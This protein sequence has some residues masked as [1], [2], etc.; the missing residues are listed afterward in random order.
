ML[1]GGKGHEAEW[2]GRESCRRADQ[3]GPVGSSTPEPALGGVAVTVVEDLI[4]RKWIADIVSAE[5]ISTQAEIAFTDA[6][7]IEGLLGGVE[8]RADGRVDPT[9]DDESRPILLAVSDNGPQMTSGSTQDGH[10]RHRPA[11][12]PAQH[13]HRP[14]LNR[15]AV[16]PRQSRVAQLWPS[17]PRRAPSR[18]GH[19]PRPLQLHP[20]FQGRH[21]LRH[22]RRRARWPGARPS[23]KPERPA[24]KRPSSAA[25][26]P[27]AAATSVPSTR[28]PTM[29]AKDRDLR[30]GLGNRSSLRYLSRVAPMRPPVPAEATMPSVSPHP[31]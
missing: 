20:S 22:A 14:G 13:S 18:A 12:R 24:L 16:R 15:V 3:G 23:A 19:G 4:S 9:V 21:R 30:G 8:A 26:L 7:G 10:V 11:L 1:E 6:L 31:T 17:R 27:S 5:E 2:P 28:V 29:L 25:H